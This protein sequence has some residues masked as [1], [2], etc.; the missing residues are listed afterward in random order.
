LDI[1]GH[2]VRGH[3]RAVV[4]VRAGPVRRVRAGR[5]VREHLPSD[6]VHA[7]EHRARPAEHPAPGQQHAGQRSTPVAHR[8]R[9]VPSD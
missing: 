1:H 9:I 7:G 6:R 5:R 4:H 8:T 3:G 2:H